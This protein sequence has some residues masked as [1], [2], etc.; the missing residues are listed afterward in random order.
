ML[1]MTSIPLILSDNHPCSYFNNR[2]ARSVFVDPF[3]DPSTSNYE[4][5]LELGFRR[6]G[7]QI[8]NRKRHPGPNRG[9][10]E[11]FYEQASGVAAA[12]S[13]TGGCAWQRVFNRPGISNARDRV[14]GVKG[15]L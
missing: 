2:T 7:D 12:A 15:A 13:D 4:Q 11:I 1:A 14:G 5:L 10:R 6:S 3:F 8:Y 9:K